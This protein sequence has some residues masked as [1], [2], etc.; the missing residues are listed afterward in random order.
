MREV[1]LVVMAKCLRAR[2][3]LFCCLCYAGVR[4]RAAYPG[5]A[6]HGAKKNGR[7]KWMALQRRRAL[8]AGGETSNG[9]GTSEDSL[10]VLFPTVSEFLCLWKWED[11]SARHAGTITLFTELGSWK[12]R[13]NDRD[14]GEVAFVS[15]RSLSCLLDAVEKGLV[16]GGLDWRP[17]QDQ[18]RRK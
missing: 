18:K 6:G 5:H 10:S 12:A 17:A 3:G 15:A 16:E 7:R 9:Q 13:V 1:I 14:T 8:V 4:G 2:S 11:G